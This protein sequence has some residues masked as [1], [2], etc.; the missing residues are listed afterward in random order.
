MSILYRWHRA[1]PSVPPISAVNALP[2]SPKVLQNANLGNPYVVLRIMG[3]SNSSN[4]GDLG[5]IQPSPGPSGGFLRCF[6]QNSYFM[7]FENYLKTCFLDR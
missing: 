6:H 1:T 4:V 2:K 5:C 3:R 7:I